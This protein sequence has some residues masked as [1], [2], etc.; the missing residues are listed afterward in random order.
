MTIADRSPDHDTATCPGCLNA[1]REDD[2][3]NGG[4]VAWAML[5]VGAVFG[6]AL[7]LIGSN[8]LAV[9]AR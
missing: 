7:Y 8:V 1:A 9:V 5:A 3:P 6:T 2:G 4:G